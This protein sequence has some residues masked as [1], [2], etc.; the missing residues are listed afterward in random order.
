MLLAVLAVGTA[1]AANP[2]S[3]ITAALRLH[4]LSLDDLSL[5]LRA[6]DEDAPRL[7][8]NTGVTR[9]P[10]STIKLLTTAA[11][12]ELLGPTF[13]WRTRVYLDGPLE[14]G[15]LAGD[16]IIQGSGDPG[17]TPERLWRHL[18]ALRERGLKDIAGDIR[19]DISAFEPPRTSRSAFDGD[20]DNPYN[21]LP[22]AFAVNDQVT[23]V[24]MRPQPL[25]GG[26]HAWLSPPLA[27]VR[28]VNQAR[29]VDAPCRNK[30]HRPSLTFAEDEAGPRLTLSGS[31]AAGCG[32]DAIARLLLDPIGHA[33]AVIRAM[34][35]AMGGRLGGAVTTGALP[36]TAT[37]FYDF[38]SE[39]LP[40]VVRDINKTSDNLATRSL[41]LTLGLEAEGAPATVEKGRAAVSGWLR[42]R[43][44]EFP[45]LVID[46]GSGLSRDTRISAESLGRLLALVYQGPMMSEL[47]ASL[48]ILGVDGTLETRLKRD[49]AAGHA[50]LKTGSLRGATGLAG[51]LEDASG[52]RWILVSLINN[53][54]LQRWRGKAVEDAI[55]RRLYASPP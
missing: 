11:A 16:L 23:R 37:P 25:G 55:L 43:G 1:G 41:F 47:F 49:P 46:N 7:A 35:E 52:R 22:V 53:P 2:P 36:A 18:W 28:L 32:E 3:E 5:Y 26:L 17:L 48:P 44:L 6:V 27:D 12:L 30:D 15:H 31:F 14:D 13:R 9:I 39:P 40:L 20:G 8:I 24:E 54:R 4:E 33:G 34:W 45:E 29:L 10:A 19:I 21:A 38:E 50:H 42:A 51:F